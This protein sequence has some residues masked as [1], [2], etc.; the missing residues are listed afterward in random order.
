MKILG[1]NENKDL[2]V[3]PNNQLV[4]RTGIEATLQACAS[5]IEAQR[6]EMQY[7][8]SRGIPTS[9][10]IWAGVPNQQRFQFYCIE[11]LEAISGVVKVLRFN[12]DII[13]NTLNYEAEIETEFGTGP[14]GNIINAV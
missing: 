7:D 8:I 4:L 6:G 13:D 10:T 3:G 14:I 1:E 5:A 2:F 9:S 12:T 11:A